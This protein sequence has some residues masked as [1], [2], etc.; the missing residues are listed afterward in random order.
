LRPRDQ[1]PRDRDALALAAAEFVRVLVEVGAAQAHRIQRLGGAFTLLGR[2][3][4]VQHGQRFGHRLQHLAPRVQAAVRVLEDHLEAGAR[5]AQCGRHPAHV[6]VLPVEQHLSGA[7]RSSA[8][9]SRASVLL[10]EPDSPTSPRLRPRCSV[11]LTP[12][13][14]C[15][16]GRVPNRCSRGSRYCRVQ[17]HFE[18]GV[19]QQRAAH[20]GMS[21]WDVALTT[22]S[23]GC[24]AP[25]AQASPPARRQGAAAV[26]DNQRAAVGEGAA[27]GM[28]ASSGTRPGMVASRVPRG[29]A[30]PRPGSKQPARIRVRQAAEDLGRG[31]ALDHRAAVHH[32]QPLHGVGHHAQVV[33]D[34]QQAHAVLAHQLGG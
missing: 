11:K 29:Q 21:A 10:P 15:T 25:R 27:G 5:A 2:A 20:V 18:Q 19:A 9:T 28:S 16:T 23:S 17:D 22:P 14:A 31:P 3:R 8:I 34:Q 1:R 24:S 26:V 7:G 12:A 32:Q 30:E 4:A 6:Q 33:A 13:S